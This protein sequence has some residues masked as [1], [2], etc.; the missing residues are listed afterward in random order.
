MP[1]LFSTLSLQD[2]LDQI[3]LKLPLKAQDI[4]QDAC[5]EDQKAMKRHYRS[6]QGID[7]DSTDVVVQA[8]PADE[9]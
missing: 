7:I 9:I 4:Y 1:S 6:K 5:R 3:D 2:R 8:P